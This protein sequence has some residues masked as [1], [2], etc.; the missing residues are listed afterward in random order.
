MCFCKKKI[1]KHFQYNMELDYTSSSFKEALLEGRVQEHDIYD[2]IAY[3]NN[4][5]EELGISLGEFLGMS[6]NQ[7]VDWV[8]GSPLSLIEMFKADY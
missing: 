2:Y 4:F 7:Y 8:T 3:Y 1:K 5:E 6:D